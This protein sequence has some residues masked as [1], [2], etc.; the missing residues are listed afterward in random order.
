MTAALKPG[1]TWQNNRHQ[2][3]Q[4]DGTRSRLRGRSAKALRSPS[5]P[6][7]STALP[8]TRT[9]PAAIT[10]IYE[11]QGTAA[12]QSADLPHGWTS[13]MAETLCRIRPALRALWQKPSGLAR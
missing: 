8:P 3:G 4:A 6:R 12:L 13:P 1:R 2:G 9:N 11:D 5:R 7:P 10:R